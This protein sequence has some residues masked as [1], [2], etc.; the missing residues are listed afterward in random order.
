MQ[1]TRVAACRGRSL[2]VPPVV[3][4]A[5]S[6]VTGTQTTPLV[7]EIAKLVQQLDAGRFAERQSASQK[8]T[9]AGKAAI[10][11]LAKAA[12][13]DSLEMTVRSIDILRKFHESS[14]RPTSHQPVGPS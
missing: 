7:E 9:A 11:A 6:Q 13:G 10:P 14:T 3:W 5:E 1:Q 12:L 4:G 2:V 8:L